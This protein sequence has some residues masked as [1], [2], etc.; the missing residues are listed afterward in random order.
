VRRI[1]P[2]GYLLAILFAAFI[3]PVSSF[4]CTLS[5]KVVRVADGDTLT[6]LTTDQRQVTI[7]LA[8]IDAPEKAQ[9]FGQRSKQSLPELVFGGDV[10]IRTEAT[11]RSGRTVG[12]V[13][14]NGTDIN[15]EQVTRG[16]AWAC[17]Q[18]LT[19]G[20][21]LDAEQVARSATWPM[22]RAESDS[23]LGV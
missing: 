17:R 20:S 22:E 13:S 1:S 14:L 16:M 10:E 6:V 3:F 9:P 18:Y 15:L 2:A 7:R 19:D 12:R 21:F 23:A 4:A 8:Q 5:G 11:D